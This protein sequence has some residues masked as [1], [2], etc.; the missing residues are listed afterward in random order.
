MYL[1]IQSQ[2]KIMYI[3]NIGFI[4]IVKT[5]MFSRFNFIPFFYLIMYNKKIL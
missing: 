1:A 4:I 5:A 2:Q 3:E